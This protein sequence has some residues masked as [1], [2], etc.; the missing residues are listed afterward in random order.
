MSQPLFAKP[1]CSPPSPNLCMYLLNYQLSLVTGKADIRS[2]I[3]LGN[4]YDL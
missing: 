2:K 1:G 4:M 3:S